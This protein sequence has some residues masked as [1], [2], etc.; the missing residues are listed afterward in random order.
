MSEDLSIETATPSSEVPSA[1]EFTTSP[2]R[3]RL[4]VE[5]YAPV[6]EV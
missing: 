6:A 3:N 5:L 4:R 2:L 1:S